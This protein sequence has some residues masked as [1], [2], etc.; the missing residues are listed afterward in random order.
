MASC[1]QTE[2]LDRLV[3]GEQE[4]FLGLRP[5]RKDFRFGGGIPSW[6]TQELDVDDE[7]VRGEV[8]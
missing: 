4:R 8:A 7:E 3:G 1:L 2:R 6:F 5:T